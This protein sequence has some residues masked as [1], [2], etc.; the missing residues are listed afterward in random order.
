M[1]IGSCGEFCFATWSACLRTL[2]FAEQLKCSG[3]LIYQDK[4]MKK[5]WTLRVINFGVGFVLWQVGLLWKRKYT[6]CPY[7]VIRGAGGEGMFLGF[8]VLYLSF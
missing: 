3:R 1:R 2:S 5:M 4:M 6:R 7:T 8:S